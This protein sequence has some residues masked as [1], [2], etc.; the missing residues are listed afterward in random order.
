MGSPSLPTNGMRSGFLSFPLWEF[1]RQISDITKLEGSPF[2]A[3]GVTDCQRFCKLVRFSE[4]PPVVDQ[5][6]AGSVK[7]Q[8]GRGWKKKYRERTIRETYCRWIR[9]KHGVFAL[10][11]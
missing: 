8:T 1:A 5:M 9:S 10:A 7:R 11:L 4:N 2:G 6:V 3:R